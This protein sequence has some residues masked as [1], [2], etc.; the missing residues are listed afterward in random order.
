MGA[1]RAH[2]PLSSVVS[3]IKVSKIAK[4]EDDSTAASF[5]APTGKL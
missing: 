4:I 1:A 5:C 3:I 2:K